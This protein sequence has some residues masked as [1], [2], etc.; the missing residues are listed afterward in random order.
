MITRLSQKRSR[1]IGSA[2]IKN[3]WE[4]ILI[5]DLAK[6]AFARNQDHCSADVTRQVTRRSPGSPQQLQQG[7][8]LLATSTAKPDYLDHASTCPFD[9]RDVTVVIDVSTIRVLEPG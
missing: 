8:V 3:Y 1:I 4:A 6:R 9:R 5:G 7:G 2:Q